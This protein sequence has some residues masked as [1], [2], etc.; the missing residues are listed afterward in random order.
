MVPVNR[1]PLDIVLIP[2]IFRG[3]IRKLL[4]QK[5]LPCRPQRS[6]VVIPKRSEE[7]AFG[8]PVPRQS[9]P[10]NKDAPAPG[11][12]PKDGA[13]VEK[14]PLNLCIN[15]K[16]ATPFRGRIQRVRGRP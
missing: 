16:A 12:F 4:N 9:P 15:R 1:I 10:D 6:N 3:E 8:V 7:S 13:G 5:A 14:P 2:V 11:Q